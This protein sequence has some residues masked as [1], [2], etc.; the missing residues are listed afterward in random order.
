MLR[1][2]SLRQYWP[3]LSYTNSILNESEL[4]SE[5]KIE[6]FEQISVK[7]ESEITEEIYNKYIVYESYK[8]KNLKEMINYITFVTKFRLII[9]NNLPYL[10]R[11]RKNF[12]KDNMFQ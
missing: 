4:K 10:K 3:T 2:S 9:P 5:F 11:L 6:N 7:Y 12:L 8:P 1:N